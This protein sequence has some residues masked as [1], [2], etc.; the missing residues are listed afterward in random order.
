[1]AISDYIA[2]FDESGDHGLT[3]IDKTFPVFVLC[4]C[5]FKI[6]A[7][8]AH[9][10]P[11]FTKLKFDHFSHDA[12]VFHSREIRKQVGP[13]AILGN[14][15]TRNR[16]MNDVTSFFTGSSCTIIA[17]GIHKERHCAKYK[18]PIDPYTISL[19]FCLERLFGMLHDRGEKGGNLTC[20]FEKRGDKEDNRLAAEFERIRGGQ[21][22][23]GKL[24]FDAVFAHKQTNMA[25]LQ[26]ADLAAYPIA[27]RF[28]DPKAANPA[29]D[30]LEPKCRRS[31][32]G[33]VWGFGLKLFP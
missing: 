9:D 11:A 31:T 29:Y 32:D 14:A 1:M 23:W 33:K 7:Y 22:V 24:P 21:N 26:I 16:F 3:A 6:D 15:A 19:L 27:R 28:I 20:I 12:V 13:F 8:L 18:N 30:A 25:G 2:Y 4:A 5:V 10:M 17:A